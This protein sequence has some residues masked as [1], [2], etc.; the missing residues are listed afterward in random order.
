M[1]LTAAF[2]SVNVTKMLQSELDYQNLRSVYY[3][4]SEVVM[5][6]ISNEARRFHVYVG[7]RVQHIRDLSDPEQWHH[8]TGKD[9]PADE[10]SRS[11]NASQLL[12]NKRWL[13]GPVFLWESDV[14]LL[15]K[16]NTAQLSSDDVEVKTNTCLLT[17]SPAREY[18]GVLLLSYLNRVSSWSKAKTTVA[19]MRRGIKNL[20]SVIAAREEEINSAKDS[21]RSRNEQGKQ[22][23]SLSVEKL[24]HSEKFILR[25]VQC[26]YF[27]H[28][29]ETLTNLKG[30]LE[31]FQERGSARRRNDTLKKTSSLYKL[32][33]FVYKNGLL[34]TGGRI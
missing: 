15:N 29:M 2:V 7:N 24:V 12:N 10:A 17:H 20:Q 28:E 5:G 23:L 34:R 8:L 22:F 19:W 14:S 16:K 11:L 1:E 6:Y 9:N 25:C 18:P 3:T 21:G 33:P 31:K 13:S 4:D 32:D 26:Q 27:N 30:N